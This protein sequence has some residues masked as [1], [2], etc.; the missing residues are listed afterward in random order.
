MEPIGISRPIRG[1]GQAQSMIQAV[2]CSQRIGDIRRKWII[3][4]DMRWSIPAVG[5]LIIADLRDDPAGDCRSRKF[6][7]QAALVMMG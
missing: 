5:P 7:C 4:A 1:I 6:G 3:T 2:G